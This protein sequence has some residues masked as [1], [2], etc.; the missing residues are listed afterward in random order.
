M[1]PQPVLYTR[2]PYRVVADASGEPDRRYL[3]IDTA[4]VRL[5]EEEDF[6]AACEWVDV[7]M[8]E[9]DVAHAKTGSPSRGG[10]R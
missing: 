6:C 3:V 10:R 2:G 7:R 5:R 4:G 8:A 9:L 1:H